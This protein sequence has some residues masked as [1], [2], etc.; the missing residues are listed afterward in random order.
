MIWGLDTKVRLYR[1]KKTFLWYQDAYLFRQNS[2][3]F[4]LKS[5][6]SGGCTI[7]SWGAHIFFGPLTHAECVP[8]W[9]NL[10]YAPVHESMYLIHKLHESVS[11][12]S[13]HTTW[14][15]VS[16]AYMYYMRASCISVSATYTTC[17]SAA[18]TYTIHASVYLLLILHASV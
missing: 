14:I 16:S 4:F 13:I 2:R 7:R 9:L 10:Q 8:P 1:H 3:L 6:F 11:R 15:S 17:I 12:I 5:F 18:A